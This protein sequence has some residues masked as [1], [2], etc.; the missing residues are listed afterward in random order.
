MAVL[1]DCGECARHRFVLFGT[2][3]NIK[4]IPGS[5]DKTITAYK[6]G[7]VLIFL[8]LCF[9][10]CVRVSTRYVRIAAPEDKRCH[11]TIEA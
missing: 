5:G 8:E 11:L 2:K 10:L 6:P 9:F 1:L 4:R 3:H 7:T